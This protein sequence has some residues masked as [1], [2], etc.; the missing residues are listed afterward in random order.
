M[1]FTLS[2]KQY[3]DMHFTYRFSNDNLT[4]ATEESWWQFSQRRTPDEHMF[5]N[6][7][8][9]MQESDLFLTVTYC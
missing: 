5:S 9:P 2:N 4:T 7:H 1:L 8:Q 6:V 3:A